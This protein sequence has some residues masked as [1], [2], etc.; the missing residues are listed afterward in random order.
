MEERNV[1]ILI[2]NFVIELIVY[3]GLVTGYFWVVLRFLGQPLAGLFKGNLPV[4]AVAALVLIVVQGVVL[5][6]VTSF[7]IKQLKLERLE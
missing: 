3:G 4:Y 5:E 6:F 2:R 1:R 7:L